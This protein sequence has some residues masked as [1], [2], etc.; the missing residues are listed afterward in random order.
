[1]VFNL[2]EAEKRKF[3]DD[4]FKEQIRLEMIFEPKLRALNR[5]IAEQAS[6]FYANTEVVINSENFQ[7]QLIGLL[8][9]QYRKVIKKFGF[10]IRDSITK[11]NINAEFQIESAEFV[12][13]ESDQ[14]APLIG[15]TQQKDIE[16]AINNGLIGLLLIMGVS[17]EE[18]MESAN[19]G[20]AQRREIL[21]AMVDSNTTF[22]ETRKTQELQRLIKRDYNQRAIGRSKTIAITETNTSANFAMELEET[23]ASEDED[24]AEAAVLAGLIGANQLING[25]LPIRKEWV[26][27][28]DDRTRATHVR[29]DGQVRNV[30][31]PFNVG[32]SL[33]RFPGDTALGAPIEEIA[34]CRCKSVPVIQ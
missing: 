8:R 1:M 16:T 13:E 17:S 3:V 9:D 31:E 4:L 2:N 18:I 5:I 11:K 6:I 29:A 26:A 20:V 27:V 25:T 19:F 22:T 33:L 23:L 32:G 24:L 10:F 7:P 12:V 30:N 21:Q 14:R 34:N 28:L 15:Q